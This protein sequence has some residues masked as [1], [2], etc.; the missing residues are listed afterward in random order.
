MKRLQKIIQ[1]IL[2]IAFMLFL[3]NQMNAQCETWNNSPDQ[4]AITDA[5]AVY[6]TF[7]KTKKYEEAF[8][9]WQKAYKAAPAADGLRDFHYT[10]G[11]KIYKDKL[12]KATDD[13]QKKEYGEMVLKL[14]D[15]VINCF[16][17]GA[18]KMKIPAA[19]RVAYFQGR[20]AFDMYYTLQTPY[21]ETH[22]V[23]RKAV[24]AAKNNLEYIILDPHA[25]VS[26]YMFSND[27]I[28]K[29]EIRAIYTELN[30]IADHNIANNQKFKTQYEQAKASMN[31][32]FLKYE[33]Q[34]FDCEYFKAK[35]LPEY[36]ADPDNRDVYR[37]I[38]KKL[39]SHGCDKADPIM[40][41]ISMKDNAY[42]A[43]EKTRIAQERRDNNPAYVANEFYKQG[44][45]QEALNKYE[46]ALAKETDPEKQASIYFSMASIEFRKL[47]KY[48][49]ARNKARKAAK[50]RAGWGKPYAL[51]GDMY[52]AS[53]SR[54]GKDAWSKSL[55][56]LA[57]LDKWSYAR[58]IDSSVD[59]GGKIA[60]YNAYKPEAETAFMQGKKA[61]QK[62]NV[63]CWIGETV[64][65]RF[66]K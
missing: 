45:Y 14:Y 6:R 53:S 65:L 51:I 5:H 39:A 56:V 43:S 16:E 23:L 11:I 26:V 4:D 29:D 62:V 7:M 12:T 42:I 41:E 38:Y 9:N 33:D 21:K 48:S 58:S 24:K 3:A 34:M 15:Q 63:G 2:P 8:D 35:L 44:K 10:D 17:S 25:R 28:T 13:A 20:K 40:Q 46:E 31:G 22:E 60:K 55:V 49:S 57:A 61:G 32:V 59:V 36:K 64:K 27:L 19:E 66:N 37:R 52:A 18:I 54:C 1:T 47:K 50:L 30:E